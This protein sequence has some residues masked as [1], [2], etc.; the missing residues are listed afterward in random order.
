MQNELVLS[1]KD[2]TSVGINSQLT[3]N[4]L[5]EVVATDLYEKFMTEINDCV[6]ATNKL[7]S[8][9]QALMNPEHDTMKAE[10]VKAG[11]LDANEKVNTGYSKINGDDW[12]SSLDCFGLN[13]YE[14]EKGTKVEKDRHEFTFSYPRGGQAK[15][16]LKITCDEKENDDNNKLKGISYSINT[17]IRKEF[18]KVISISTERF[19]SMHKEIV[20]HNERIE[21]VMSLIPANGLLSVERFTREARVKMNKKI[22]A[23]QPADFKKKMEQLFKI[24][25]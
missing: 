12:A 4:D 3:S 8:K 19:K 13:L 1:T 5:L 11:L 23:S 6:A 16:K 7:R 2:L 9:Y 21:T 22:L 18:E 17:T 15:L 24:K 14:K 25:L 20:K 10:I